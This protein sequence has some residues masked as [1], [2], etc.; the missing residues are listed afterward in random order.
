MVA[1]RF[2]AVPPSNV[3]RHTVPQHLRH[4]TLPSLGKNKYSSWPGLLGSAREAAGFVRWRSLC[5]AR[6]TLSDHFTCDN[7]PTNITGGAIL[8][9]NKHVASPTKPSS[10]HNGNRWADARNNVRFDENGEYRV[11]QELLEGKKTRFVSRVM[12][13]GTNY[14]GFQ[15]QINGRRTVQVRQRFRDH[16]C[17]HKEGMFDLRSTFKFLSRK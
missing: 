2:F 6:D 12:Y 16:V 5:G 4:V 11:Y 3:A 8:N 13:D 17:G 7:K 10:L 15:L 14:H 9:E 1:L